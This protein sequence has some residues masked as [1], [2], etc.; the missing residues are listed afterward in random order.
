MGT[1]TESRSDTLLI[2]WPLAANLGG[3][4]AEEALTRMSMDLFIV[5]IGDFQNCPEV[6]AAAN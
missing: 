3:L 6:E 2:S 5:F 1:L 4:W